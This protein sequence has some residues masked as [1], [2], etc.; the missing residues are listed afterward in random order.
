MFAFVE[1]FIT[2]IFT[3]WKNWTY[4]KPNPGK[5]DPCLIK[6]FTEA[7]GDLLKGIIN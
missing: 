3:A 4:C 2:I 5:N 7:A 6:A 1:T